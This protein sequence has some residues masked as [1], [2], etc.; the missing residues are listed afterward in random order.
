VALE[1]VPHLFTLFFHRIINRKEN[2]AVNTAI[3]YTG[4]ALTG[5]GYGKEGGVV[6][7]AVR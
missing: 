6:M 3:E 5:G 4:F 2:Y 7:L 1:V